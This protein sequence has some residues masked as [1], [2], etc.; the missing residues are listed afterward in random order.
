LELRTYVE[1]HG[2]PDNTKDNRR[3]LGYAENDKGRKMLDRDLRKIA[4]MA[5]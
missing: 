4:S 3:A 2:A 1:K 5:E